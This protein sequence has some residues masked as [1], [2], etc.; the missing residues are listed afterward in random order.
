M[1]VSDEAELRISVSEAR[2]DTKF[3]EFLGRTEAGFQT[4][5]GE[6]QTGF[7]SLRG[8]IQALNVR[9]D[10]IEKSTAGLRTTIIGTGIAT[11]AVLIAVLAYGQTWF[12]IGVSAREV[13]RATIAEYQIAHPEPAQR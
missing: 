12:G 10:A 1:T 7:A 9:V 6:M 13:I 5:R 4:L 11:V 3:A 2:T 8:E